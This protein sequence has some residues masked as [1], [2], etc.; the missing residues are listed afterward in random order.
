MKK[1]GF[2]DKQNMFF[3]FTRGLLIVFHS[4]QFEGL[5]LTKSSSETL[6][7]LP[8][9]WHK[10]THVFF[11]SFFVSCLFIFSLVLVYDVDIDQGIH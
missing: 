10:K 1:Y 5:C 11:F 7:N 8:Y 3:I 9:F 2:L 6:Q 4:S